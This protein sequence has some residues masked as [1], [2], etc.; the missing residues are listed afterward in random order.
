MLVGSGMVVCW[1][2]SICP[3]ID[4]ICP[5]SIDKSFTEKRNEPDPQVVCWPATVVAWQFVSEKV[6][7]IGVLLKSIRT[8]PEFGSLVTVPV[9]VAL[10]IGEPPPAIP[11]GAVK[12]TRKL[13]VL[14]V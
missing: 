8:P 7:R 11:S 12:V 6:K 1:A 9:R 5:G 13:K 14:P 2:D 10:K 3:V 4:A